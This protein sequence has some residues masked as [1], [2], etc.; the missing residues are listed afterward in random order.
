MAPVIVCATCG[1]QQ[2]DRPVL[3]PVCPVCA[4]P[5]QYVGAGGQRWTTLEELAAEGHRTQ[6]RD[7]E[8]GLM[9]IG[10]TP[11]LAIGQ[12]SL[13]VVTDAGNVLWDVPGFVDDA[14]MAAVEQMGGLAAVS[15][16]HPHF[17]GVM[18]E[19]ADAFDAPVLL[20][21][22][23]ASWLQRPPRRLE[24]YA[25]RIEAVPGVTLV[26]TGGH[27]P[28]SAVVHW[29][30]GAGGRGALLTGDSLTVVADRA[31]LS[32]M[33]SYPN[34]IPLDARALDGIEVA[35]AG[36]TYARVYGGWWSSVISEG[37]QDAVARSLARYRTAITDVSRLEPHPR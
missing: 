7:V 3:P 27:F 24:R 29:P 14:A 23:D 10:V 35:L 32:F 16:S 34:L 25:D 21:E 15:A 1:V 20:P 4:D 28:G 26:R 2:A 30:A 37:A 13:L 33:W 9:G 36:L 31:W 17:Y 5:R 12:R 6:V 22:A 19:W 8:P 11:K 18:A